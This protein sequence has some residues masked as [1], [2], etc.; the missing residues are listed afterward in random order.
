MVNPQPT[1]L[2]HP[3]FE[4]PSVD[5]N[6]IQIFERVPEPRGAS[7]NFQHSLTSI[8][9][10]VTVSSL[11]GANDWSEIVE[12]ASALS[13]W[14]EKHVDLSHGVPSEYTLKRVFGLLP[15]HTVDAMLR[16][17]MDLMRDKVDQ[18]LISF[19]GKSLRAS[20]QESEDLRAVHILNA[21]SADNRICLGQL[22]VDD[23]SNEITAIP[24]L[25]GMLDLKGTIITTDALNTQKT[26]ANQARKQ[27][28]DYILPL[29]G[30]HKELKE[31]VEFEFTE[32][33]KVGF[34][35]IDSD[36][37]EQTEK[38][39]G[40]VEVRTYQ[41]LDVEGLPGL[42]E[43]RDAKTACLVT[44]ERSV[45]G[46]TSSEQVLYISSCELDAQQFARAIRGHWGVENGLHWG[47]DVVFREDKHAYRER[48]GATNLSAVRKFCMGLLSKEKT[49]K[50]SK[51]AK[52][53]RALA[54]PGYRELL[55]KTVF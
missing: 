19:D 37:F 38:S 48:R 43:W 33:E 26:T 3:V 46:K 14:I 34:K 55:F 1:H 24:M 12:V 7:C 23:K 44:R 11:C 30:N 42:K 52:R 40:R 51:S 31:E 29:K 18:E 49:N 54:D 53:L 47:L 20:R 6:L 2:H 17:V 10:I 21:W 15:N 39:R 8:L 36:E 4:H 32:A 5:T 25:M 9:F 13:D 22:K 35:G 27:G 16:E 50:R 45:K 28:A 41:C